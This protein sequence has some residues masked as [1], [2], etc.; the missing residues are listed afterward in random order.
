M[1]N[2][3]NKVGIISDKNVSLNA[4]NPII[5]DSSGSRGSTYAVRQVKDSNI[6]NIPLSNVGTEDIKNWF[7]SYVSVV[8]KYNKLKA[9]TKNIKWSDYRNA[10]IVGV[11]VSVTTETKN[12]DY[13]NNNDA[14]ITLIPICG[15]G[16]GTTIRREDTGGTT[17]VSNNA[18][19]TVNGVDGGGGGN[20]A[21]SILFTIS[22][23]GISFQIKYT[24]SYLG[25]PSYIFGTSTCGINGAQYPIYPGETGV[26]FSGKQNSRAYGAGYA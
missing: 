19:Y 12:G 16:G 20:A 15:N 22:N 3:N 26:F 11:K 1:A 9:D 24:A 8:G 2:P 10:G 18:P 6:Q 25:G 13:Y 17:V 4:G 23:G 14:S 21:K 7:E 5:T